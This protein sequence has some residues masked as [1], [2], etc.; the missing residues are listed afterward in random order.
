M[1]RSLEVEGN[2]KISIDCELE[3]VKRRIN[4]KESPVTKAMIFRIMPE[5]SYNSSMK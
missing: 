5:K 2:L 3:A 4:I 1:K